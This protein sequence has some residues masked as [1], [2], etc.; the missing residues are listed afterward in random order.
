MIR[1]VCWLVR[2]FV[3]TLFVGWSECSRRPALRAAGVE[4]AWGRWPPTCT[5][6][7]FFPIFANEIV[8]STYIF[9]L[10]TKIAKLLQ[11]SPE[12]KQDFVIKLYTMLIC[13]FA[14]S[15][16]VK[17]AKFLSIPCTVNYYTVF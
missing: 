8:L 14:F 13:S 7:V 4:H 10:L 11:Y 16:T 9:L 17:C 6:L 5:F 3:L 12:T 1:R 2:N 15:K